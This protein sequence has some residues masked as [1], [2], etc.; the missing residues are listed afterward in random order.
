MELA[1]PFCIYNSFKSYGKIFHK[2]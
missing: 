2:V 1:H